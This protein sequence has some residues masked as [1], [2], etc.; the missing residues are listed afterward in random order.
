MSSFCTRERKG[1]E[2]KTV[3]AEKIRGASCTINFSYLAGRVLPNREEVTG[4]EG[5]SAITLPRGR[6]DLPACADYGIIFFYTGG[7][8]LTIKQ[9]RGN[10]SRVTYSVR[11]GRG[12][13]SRI[14]RDRKNWA[15]ERKKKTARADARFGGAATVTRKRDGTAL[16]NAERGKGYDL[17]SSAFEGK[18]SSRPR[19][20]F[21]LEK[22]RVHF[23]GRGTQGRKAN[24]ALI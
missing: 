17:P 1:G 22:P 20:S 10:S 24:T 4:K 14:C 18:L 16:G 12:K 8:S 2:K 5:M 9:H 3:S 19:H 15:K 11:H 13:G 7:V 21:Y 6:R 23:R